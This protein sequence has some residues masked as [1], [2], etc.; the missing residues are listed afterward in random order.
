MDG[1]ISGL[2]ALFFVGVVFA[3]IINAATDGRTFKIFSLRARTKD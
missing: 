1:I 3:V 2:F